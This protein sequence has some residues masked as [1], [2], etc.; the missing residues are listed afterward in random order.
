[1]RRALTPR[2]RRVGAWLLVALL[3][4]AFYSLL[5]VPLW[6]APLQDIDSQMH[7]LAEQ[8]LRYQRLLAQ[9]EALEQG[10]QAAQGDDVGLLPG[11]D[12]SAVAADLM[13][14]VAQRVKDN[15]ALNGGCQVT[16]RM[17]IVTQDQAA[18]P[19]RQVRLS[20]DLDCA[21]QPL[22]TLLQQLEGEQPLLFVDELNIRRAANAPASGGAGRLGVHLLLSGYLAPAQAAR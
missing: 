4:A 21:I 19:F 14:Q 12:P 16:Q 9:R 7:T 2:E 10:V 1:M 5:V 8:R 15:E 11:E 6:I 17:P 20:L 22:V 13:Q 18:T 3:A